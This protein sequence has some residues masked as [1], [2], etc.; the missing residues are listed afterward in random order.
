MTG[1]T[2]NGNYDELMTFPFKLTQK[3]TKVAQPSFYC[4][5]WRGIAWDGAQ[6]RRQQGPF[7]PLDNM[8]VSAGLKLRFF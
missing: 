1:R 6:S 2:L 4:H 7:D 3:M 8:A 5:I